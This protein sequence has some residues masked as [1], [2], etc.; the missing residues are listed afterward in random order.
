[1][2]LPVINMSFGSG[3][4]AANN[5]HGDY[6]KVGNLSPFADYANAHT[7]GTDDPLGAEPVGEADSFD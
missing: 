6:D 3:W 7:V 1:M 2:G 4:T 5:W